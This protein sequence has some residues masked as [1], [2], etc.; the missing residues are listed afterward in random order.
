[1]RSLA[2]ELFKLVGYRMPVRL[3]GAGIGMVGFWNVTLVLRGTAAGDAEHLFDSALAFSGVVLPLTYF[4][5]AVSVLNGDVSDGTLRPCL[6]VSPRPRTVLLSKWAASTVGAVTSAV[7]AA[8]ALAI[9]LSIFPG[10]ATFL[11]LLPETTVKL[12][13]QALLC[14]TL[15][16]ALHVATGYQ[17]GAWVVLGLL[18][19]MHLIERVLG[20]ALPGR[21]GM[22]ASPFRLIDFWIRDRWGATQF[23]DLATLGFL[24]LTVAVVAV[25]V[26]TILLFLRFSDYSARPWGRTGALS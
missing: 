21:A 7:L 5:F 8:A 14:V 2:T 3:A 15:S 12:V 17:A 20:S 16:F 11:G 18:A 13:V 26:L 1:M 4:A 10:G 24:P 9:A 23:S 25:S 19:W 22:F 6:V